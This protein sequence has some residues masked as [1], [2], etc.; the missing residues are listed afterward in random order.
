M[1]LVERKQLL[2]LDRLVAAD[3]SLLQLVEDALKVDIEGHRAQ[4]GSRVGHVAPPYTCAACAAARAF[5]I[6]RKRSRVAARRSFAF[7]MRMTSCSSCPRYCGI[8]ICV[9]NPARNGSTFEKTTTCS[10]LASLNICSSIAPLLTKDAA[11]S[12]KDVTIRK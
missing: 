5:A 12:Q 10:P 6:C 8:P 9:R 3:A 11:M 2:R 1:D 7:G 4:V